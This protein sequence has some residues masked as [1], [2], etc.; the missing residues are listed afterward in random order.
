[1]LLYD[2]QGQFIAQGNSDDFTRGHATGGAFYLVAFYGEPALS[3]PLKE[4]SSDL[5][6]LN[7]S[8][9]SPAAARK[10]KRSRFVYQSLQHAPITLTP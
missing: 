10:E 5:C 7:I 2:K 9:E 8:I 6:H 3:S 1:M 4:G